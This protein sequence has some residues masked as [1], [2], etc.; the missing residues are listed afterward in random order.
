[1]RVPTDGLLIHKNKQAETRRPS[2]QRNIGA[3]LRQEQLTNRRTEEGGRETERHPTRRNKA[4]P[5]PKERQHRKQSQRLRRQNK[6]GSVSWCGDRGRGERE[7]LE[8]KIIE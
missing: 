4:E 3:I 1:M 7:I 6:K 8:S 2:H 5:D